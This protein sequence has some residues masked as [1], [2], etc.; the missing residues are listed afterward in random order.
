M[1]IFPLEASDR[2]RPLP[3][4]SKAAVQREARER[5]EGWKYKKISLNLPVAL[6]FPLPSQM[7]TPRFQGLRRLNATPPKKLR[8]KLDFYT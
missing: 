1:I 2:F 3:R 6:S 4:R 8:D 7:T 5:S